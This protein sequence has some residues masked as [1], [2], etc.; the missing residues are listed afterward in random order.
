VTADGSLGSWSFSNS[1]PAVKLSSSLRQVLQRLGWSGLLPSDPFFGSAQAEPFFYP[2][3]DCV[4]PARAGAV[5]DAHFARP[6]GLVLDGPE[7]D[8]K[9]AGYGIMQH[10]NFFLLLCQHPCRVQGSLRGRGMPSA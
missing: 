1:G 5:K 4:V 3:H 9:L 8:G 7:H 6:R 10:S 2:G